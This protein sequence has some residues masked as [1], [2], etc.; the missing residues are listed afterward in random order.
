MNYTPLFPNFTPISSKEW[1]QKIQYDLKGADY[2]EEMVW[3]SPEGIK[4]KPFYNHEDFSKIEH[5]AKPVFSD[6]KIAHTITVSSA[7]EAKSRVTESLKM[8]AESLFFNLFNK[9]TPIEA[10]ISDND[11]RA[12]DLHFNLD[13]QS[14]T[15]I[16]K[17]CDFLNKDG[18]LFCVHIDPINRFTSTGN[19]FSSQKDDFLNLNKCLDITKTLSIDS[20][21]YQNAGANMV[22]QL[23]YTLAHANEYFNLLDTSTIKKSILKVAVGSNYFFEIAKIRALRKLWSLLAPEFDLP[24]ECHIIATPS[25]RNKTVYAYNTNILRTTTEYMSAI[26]GGANTIG[27]LPYDSFYHTENRFSN[28]IAL[29]QLLLLK[30]ES[31]FNFNEDPTYGTYYIENLTQQL[32]QKALELFKQIEASGGFLEQLK[33]G[34]I[35]KKIRESANKE[36]AKLENGE[37]SLVGTNR[38]T[39]SEDRMKNQLEVLPFVSK[40]KRKTLIEPIIAKRLSEKIELERLLKEGWKAY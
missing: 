7:V 12:I 25:L 30:N 14:N 8:G 21:T 6:W 4:V 24:A 34:T 20:L 37:N 27:T 26:L 28:R 39:N 17:L 40:N 32:C 5:R 18:A 11:L 10:L 35:Q 9:D 33:A 31:H 23:A 29:N 1:K 38:Y 3:E 16:Q 13:F 19:W 15:Y 22:Q 36:Q 2:N